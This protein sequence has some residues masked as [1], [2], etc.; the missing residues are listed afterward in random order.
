MIPHEDIRTEGTYVRPPGLIIEPNDQQSAVRV[1]HIPTGLSVECMY[2][3]SQLKNRL[4][5]LVGLEAMLISI[6]EID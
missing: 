5:A 4:L 2:Y 6:G 3:R 1:T